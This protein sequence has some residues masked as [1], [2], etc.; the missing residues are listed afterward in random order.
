[1]LL[2]VD[3][4]DELGLTVDDVKAIIAGRMAKVGHA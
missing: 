3:L 2:R 4:M 1:M